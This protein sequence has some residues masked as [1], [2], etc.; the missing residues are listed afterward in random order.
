M[1]FFGIC[2]KELAKLNPKEVNLLVQ[3][4]GWSTISTDKSQLLSV[5]NLTQIEKRIIAEF[6]QFA[7]TNLY[8]TIS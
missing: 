8:H 4:A 1:K 3:L 6:N 5:E 7:K 2:Q